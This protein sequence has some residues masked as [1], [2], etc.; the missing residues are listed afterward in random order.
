M[1]KVLGPLL[2]I[3]EDTQLSCSR[4]R[5][6]TVVDCRVAR[7]ADIPPYRTHMLSGHYKDK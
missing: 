3:S 5:Y 1:Q 7:Q 2:P 4:I 6:K